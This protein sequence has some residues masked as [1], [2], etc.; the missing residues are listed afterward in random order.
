MTEYRIEFAIQRRRA[1]DDEDDFTEIG[2]GSSGAWG[3]L[4]ACAHM[5]VSAVQNGEW[6]KEAGM[7]S[8]DDVLSEIKDSPTP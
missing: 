2:F 8:P 1:T 7:P 3:S 4:D 6:E 5:L